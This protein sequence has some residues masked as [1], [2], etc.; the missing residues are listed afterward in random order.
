MRHLLVG[1]GVII[2]H[3]GP[4]YLNA[5][6]INRALQ[7]ICSGRFPSHLYPKECADLVRVLAREHTRLLTGE[8]DAYAITSYDRAALGSL[9]RRYN[10][11]R[12]YAPAD[13]G[14]EDYFLLFELVYNKLGIGNPERFNCR[15]VLRR[16]FLDAIYNRGQIEQVHQAFPTGFVAWLMEHDE[17]FTTNYDSN[18][19]AATGRVVRHLH[20]SFR[21]L[22]EGYEPS[23][24]RNQIGEDLLDGEVVDS[25]YLHL[26]SNCLV[27][28]VG[29][30]K[31]FSMAWSPQANNAM[32]KLLAGYMQ[33]PD[34]RRQIE[35]WPDSDDL[36]RRLR[37]AVE[38]KAE[39]PELRHQ[40]Q[41]PHRMLAE[42]EG[43]LEIVGLSPFNDLHLFEQ[44]IHNPK[45]KEIRY[46][47]FEHTE[48][49]MVEELFAGKSLS[50]TD[51][52]DLWK[53]CEG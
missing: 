35:N 20:G 23:S 53:S 39:H 42:L 22:G 15:S 37:K 52:R 30:I 11:H 4:E 18:I 32:D 26:Y 40:E 9:K 14:F 34:L 31:S 25:G 41:Y 33:D 49:S 6:I 1:N 38:L 47:V 21:V 19:E 50:F 36:V 43:T 2:Q 12:A 8:Y 7:N 5:R 3:G 13:I 28:Y 27:S 44:V 46:H 51:V 16:L 48:G 17:V 10:S 24:F 29:E 45:I